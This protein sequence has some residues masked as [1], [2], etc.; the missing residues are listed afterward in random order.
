MKLSWLPNSQNGLMVGD[1]IATAFSNGVPHGVFAV[2]T[3]DCGTTFNEAMYTG[4]GLSAAVAG[5]QLSSANDKPLH[6]FS[7]KVEREQ[8][9]KGRIPPLSGRG[10]G[11]SNPPR[12]ISESI[13]GIDA[14]S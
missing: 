6:K 9:E 11:Q 4:Q 8:P 1:Y 13:V 14:E 10:K 7:D 12:H 3:A 2:A 5:K